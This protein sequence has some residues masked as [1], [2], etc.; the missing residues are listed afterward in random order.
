MPRLQLPPSA[1]LCAAKKDIA[2][3]NPETVV[4][5]GFFTSNFEIEIKDIR[6]VQEG[7]DSLQAFMPRDTRRKLQGKTEINP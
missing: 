6:G 3:K 5:S 7:F 4:V 1:Q 2:R